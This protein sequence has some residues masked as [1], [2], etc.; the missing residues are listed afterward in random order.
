MA[1][2]I[3]HDIRCV[4]VN[5][6]GELLNVNLHFTTGSFRIDG[7][8]DSKSKGAQHFPHVQSVVSRIFQGRKGF[9]G[10]VSDDESEPLRTSYSLYKQMIVSQ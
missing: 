1:C 9:V 3:E 2:V 7:I 8:L 4:F 6:L 10:R 5:A